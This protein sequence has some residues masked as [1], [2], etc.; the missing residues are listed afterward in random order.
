[1]EQNKRIEGSKKL[2]LMMLMVSGND[3]V[4]PEEL[5]RQTI[6][7]L[8]LES[9]VNF[10]DVNE[11]LKQVKNQEE[12]LA[13]IKGII[14]THL[15]LSQMIS[16]HDVISTGVNDHLEYLKDHPEEKGDTPDPETIMDKLFE[17]N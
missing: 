11:D 15:T 5:K 8:E 9:N 17:S 16:L 4:A 13:I 3:I 1:M 6:E 14:L 2:L 10:F 12:K 7:S